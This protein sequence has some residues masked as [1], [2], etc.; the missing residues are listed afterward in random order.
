MANRG[1]NR[2]VIPGWV[3]GVIALFIFVAF[4][5]YVWSVAGDEILAAVGIIQG[6]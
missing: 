3:W 6:Q 4:I 1:G 5:A 2:E